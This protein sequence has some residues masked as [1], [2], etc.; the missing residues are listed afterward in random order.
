[1]LRHI[2]REDCVKTQKMAFCKP[3]R[4]AS[5]ETNPADP[6]NVNLQFPEL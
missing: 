1:M 2:H 3:K 6:L 4:E 5:K